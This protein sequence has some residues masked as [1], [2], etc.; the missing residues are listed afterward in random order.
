[1]KETLLK[2]KTHIES[3]TIILGDFNTP[4]SPTDRSLKQELS[5]VTVKIIEVMNQM[6]LTDIYRTFHPK[7]KEYTF[8]SAPRGT[9]SKI[10]HIIGNKTT[11]KQYKKTEII[12]CTLSDHHDLRLVFNNRKN[13][14]KFTY[15]WKLIIGEISNS[16]P[17]AKHNKSNLQQPTTNVKLNSDILE[18]I[19]PKLGIRQGCSFSLHLF[20]IIP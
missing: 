17:R 20:N 15:T 9:F 19:P 10:N 11:L 1:M 5:R 16:R 6:D 14:R 12:L 13:N 8:F 2:F 4:L 3:H 7:T 18:A